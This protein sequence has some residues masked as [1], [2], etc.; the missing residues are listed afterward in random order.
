LQKQIKIELE[1]E[2]L[3]IPVFES[4]QALLEKMQRPLLQLLTPHF[5]HRLRLGLESKINCFQQEKKIYIPVLKVSKHTVVKLKKN[6]IKLEKNISF[7]KHFS[8]KC[9]GDHSGF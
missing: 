1:V 4:Q 8:K 5:P 6:D 2:R 7:S 9:N 3:Y